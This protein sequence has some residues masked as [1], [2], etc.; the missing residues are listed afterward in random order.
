MLP[1]DRLPAQQFVY[2][3]L[4]ESRNILEALKGLL[5]EC[6]DRPLTAEVQTLAT[7]W[8]PM[9][10]VWLRKHSELVK[11]LRLSEHAEQNWES[12]IVQ[13]GKTLEGAA[14]LRDDASALTL[15]SNDNTMD[16]VEMI[17]RYARHLHEV[18]EEIKNKTYRD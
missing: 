2:D 1:S 5:T 18:V 8:G 3:C 15:P 16:P 13:W 6:S 17:R 10:N 11:E 4:Y 9:L 7:K 12:L 14:E